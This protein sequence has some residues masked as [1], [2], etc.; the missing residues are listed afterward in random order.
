[1]SKRVLSF[2]LITL[3][4]L[5]VAVSYY[6]FIFSRKPQV[7]INKFSGYV[8]SIKNTE[9]TLHGAFSGPGI[10]PEDLMFVQNFSFKTD[11]DTQFKK[12]DIRWPTWEELATQGTSGSFKIQDLP[13]TVGDGS[14][15]DLTSLFSL[16][17]SASIYMEVDFSSSIYKSKNPIASS[18]FYQLMGILS[19][20]P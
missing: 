19:P 4:L 1:M 2:L 3:V 17:A 20:N 12:A 5:I 6:F 10:I 14:F 7:D 8:V 13:R 16:N 18:V 11:K 9:I 15:D